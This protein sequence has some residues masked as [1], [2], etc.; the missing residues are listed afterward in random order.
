MHMVINHVHFGA[1][2]T[3]HV[4]WLGWMWFKIGKIPWF[5]SYKSHKIITLH[6]RVFDYSIWSWVVMVLQILEF[7][8]LRVLLRL[9]VHVRSKVQFDFQFLKLHQLFFCFVFYPFEGTGTRWKLQWNEKLKNMSTNRSLSTQSKTLSN[10]SI[11]L[12]SYF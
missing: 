1:S 11:H 7:P 8:F 3:I 10:I 12:G 5:I 9:L 4:C 6:S 2:Q